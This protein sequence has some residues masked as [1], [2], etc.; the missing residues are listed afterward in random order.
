MKID[1]QS[2]P[3]KRHVYRLVVGICVQDRG[4]VAVET[5]H[6]A[7]MPQLVAISI[8]IGNAS[9][10]KRGDRE[11]S[12]DGEHDEDDL[13]NRLPPSSHSKSKLRLEHC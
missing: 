11:C 13:E 9:E 5:I 2:T 6:V 8:G 4:R 3:Y 12:F 10:C 7:V 1:A